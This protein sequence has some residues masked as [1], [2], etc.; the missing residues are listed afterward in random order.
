MALL[1][2]K[3]REMLRNLL[4]A[5]SKSPETLGEEETREQIYSQLEEIYFCQGPEGNYRHFYSDIFS[6]LTMID[7]D[8]EKSI[9]ELAGN[10]GF[11]QEEYRPKKRR[12]C[13][14]IK[15]ITNSLNKLYDHVNL[16]VSR[17]NYLKEA[18]KKQIARDEVDK[19]YAETE[20]LKHNIDQLNEEIQETA[21]DAKKT[22][23]EAQKEST[24]ILGIFAAIVLA[25][26]GGMIFSTSVFENIGNASIYKIGLLAILVAFALLNIIYWL[27]CFVAKLQGLDNIGFQ[28]KRINLVLLGIAVLVIVAWLVDAHQLAQRLRMIFYL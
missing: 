20:K 7:L 10:L 19:I 11:L 13:D 9:D 4:F 12:G 5:L 2:E 22:V 1:D 27:L 18:N 8:Q 14:E 23:K 26:T 24:A 15:D 28:I 3:R 6:W 16:D 17:I 25:F 21:R